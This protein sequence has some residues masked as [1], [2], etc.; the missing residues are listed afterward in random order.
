MKKSS[1]F[2]LVHL[3][4]FAIG[5]SL[6]LALPQNGSAT[7]NVPHAAFAEWAE[8]PA[9]G[10]LVVGAFYDESESY[11][12]WANGG[13]RY[14]VDTLVNGEHYGIDINQG[15]FTFQ[16]G[17]SDKVGGGL[18]RRRDNGRLAHF[19]KRRHSGLNSEDDGLDGYRV[20]RALPDF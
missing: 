5:T 19:F 8:L 1:G 9:P 20:W 14:N 17:I 15:D 2:K 6:P 13:Q 4:A 18:K 3:V 10:Q 11:H 16:Y 12:I 7:E